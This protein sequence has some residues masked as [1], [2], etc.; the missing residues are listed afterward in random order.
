MTTILA[1]EDAFITMPIGPRKLFTAVRQ[2]QTQARLK[3]RNRIEMAR[4]VNVLTAQHAVKFVYGVDDKLLPVVKKYFATRRHSSLLE[5]L[6][7]KHGHKIV[8][9]DSPAA[10]FVKAD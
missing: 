2:S 4:D 10:T 6:A 8:A 1:E 7:V 5:R 3:A 9:A